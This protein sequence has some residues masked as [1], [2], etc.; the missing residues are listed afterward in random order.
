LSH[1]AGIQSWDI[2]W[3]KTNSIKTEWRN[4]DTLTNQR[5][6]ASHVRQLYAKLESV[7]SSS[8]PTQV[9]EKGKLPKVVMGVRF[10][11]KRNNVAAI[12][13][14]IS[15][16]NSLVSRTTARGTTKSFITRHI[17]KTSVMGSLGLGFGLETSGLVPITAKRNYLEMPKHY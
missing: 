6:A 2:H 9:G 17:H 10:E 7:V 15:I 12:F 16:S 4:Y 5:V 11:K 14:K 3:S 1:L 13:T 8:K